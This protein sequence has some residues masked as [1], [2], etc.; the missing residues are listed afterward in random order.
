[1]PRPNL[2]VSLLP[3]PTVQLSVKVNLKM[4]QI[5]IIEKQKCIIRYSLQYSYVFCA[6]VRSV[7]C[8]RIPAFLI[9]LYP[10]FFILLTLY[11]VG[12][13]SK[14]PW[15]GSDTKTH[16]QVRCATAWD[17]VLACFQKLNITVQITTK[18]IKK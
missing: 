15:K 14:L 4:L 11:L 16:F 17:D 5:S 8:S 2:V 13:K 9:Y 12:K 7:L 6:V 3:P 1:L 10:L 18:Y